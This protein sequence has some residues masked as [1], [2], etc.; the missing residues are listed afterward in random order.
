MKRVA[1]TTADMELAAEAAKRSERNYRERVKSRFVPA[2]KKA[3]P[4]DTFY[5]AHCAEIAVA[6]ELGLPWHDGSMEENR[7]AHRADVGTD[8]E[9]R[10]SHPTR[11]RGPVLK[12]YD[13][14]FRGSQDYGHDG[15]KFWLTVSTPPFVE[16]HGWL[17]GHEVMKGRSRRVND[18]GL[19]VFEVDGTE[20]R[21]YPEVQTMGFPLAAPR[22]CPSCR[23]L[24]PPGTTCAG[25]WAPW[26]P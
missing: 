8:V 22:V 20:V 21:P 17:Y 10:T 4:Y 1:L 2:G 11:D 9:V 6:R 16:L 13:T 26:R 23:E 14:A 15:R 5:R 24:H 19:R 12:V 7:R 3:V 25:G 18:E